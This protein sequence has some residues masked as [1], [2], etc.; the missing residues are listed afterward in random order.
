MNQALTDIHQHLLWGIDDGADSRETMHAMLREAHAQGIKAVVAS[1]HAEPGFQPFDM[2]LYTERLCEAQSFCDSEKLDIRVLSGAEIMWTY[3][4]PLSLRQGK[5]PTIGGTDYVL[6]ELWRN[7]T[8]QSARDAVNQLTR[9][10][11]C[12][13]LAHPERYLTFLRSPKKLLRFRNETG[14]LLQVNADTILNPQNFWERRF[15][16]FLLKEGAVDAVA[17]DAHN[18]VSRPVNMK[19]AYQWLITHTDEAYA[20]KLVTFGGEPV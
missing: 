2:G 1:S 4:A 5:L 10:G 6:L 13:V 14:A 15:T 8:C 9:A 17:S 11:Y 20:K 19:K 3:Q 18:C 12:P 7:I 16:E